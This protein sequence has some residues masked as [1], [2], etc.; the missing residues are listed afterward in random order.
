MAVTQEPVLLYDRLVAALAETLNLLS[1]STDNLDKTHISNLIYTPPIPPA[2]E[3]RIRAK[4]M[5][6]RDEVIF[7]CRD[8][9]TEATMNG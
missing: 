3:L 6:A 1:A 4:E 5:E 2:D 7:F 9:L 8:V